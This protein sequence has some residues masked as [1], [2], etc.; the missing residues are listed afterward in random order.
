MNQYKR[1]YTFTTTGRYG[2]DSVSVQEALNACLEIGML[3]HNEVGIA[4][5]EG[6]W[7]LIQWEI[8]ISRLPFLGEKCVVKTF[9]GDFHRFAVSRVYIIED[10]EGNE[11]LRANSRWVLMDLENRKMVSIS[12]E[13]LKKIKAYHV[14]EKI[15][16]TKLEER[17]YNEK[18]VFPLQRRDFDHIGHINNLVYI[19][20]L[21]ETLTEEVYLNYEI[22]YLS[23]GY[24]KEGRRLKNLVIEN[25]EESNTDEILLSS[26]FKDESDILV[27]MESKWNKL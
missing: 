5:R 9:I 13:D 3:Q 10:K 12:R 18:F 11:I 8:Y 1:D 20:Y 7:V 19:D 21:Y 14:D 4:K 16:F 6:E 17:S 25:K 15:K 26:A 27:L 24:K 2:K 22:S 23:I